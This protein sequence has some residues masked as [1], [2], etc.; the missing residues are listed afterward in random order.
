MV[1]GAL[2]PQLFVLVSVTEKFP[3]TPKEW[4]G[5]CRIEVCPS[6][7]LQSQDDGRSLERSEN[8]TGIPAHCGELSEKSAVGAGSTETG[9]DAGGAAPHAFWIASVTV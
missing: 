3:E 5:F 9:A 7:K 6:P 4:E 8:A 1:L 2:A